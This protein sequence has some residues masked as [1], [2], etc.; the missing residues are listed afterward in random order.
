MLNLEPIKEKWKSFGFNVSEIDGHNVN[1]LKNNFKRFYKD[2]N[3][4]P[5]ITICHTIKGAGFSLQ[6]IILTGITEII[7]HLKR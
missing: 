3:F 1:K 5:S 2:N 4:K 7:L 6:K